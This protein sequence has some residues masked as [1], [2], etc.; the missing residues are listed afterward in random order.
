MT[1]RSAGRGAEVRSAIAVAFGAGS[2]GAAVGLLAASGSLLARAAG[3]PPAAHLAGAIVAVLGLGLGRCALRHAG[4][5]V[6]HDAALRTLARSRV[7]LYEGLSARTP[8]GLHGRPYGR[9][10]GLLA[11][12]A[13][14]VVGRE[15]HGL[16]PMAAAGAAGS[17]AVVVEWSLLPPAGMALLGALMLGGVGAPWAAHRAAVRARRRSA[18]AR[19]E[20][21][22]LAVE[23]LR[24]LPDLLACDAA[25]RRLHGLRRID[26]VVT[27]AEGRSAWSAGLAAGVTTLATGAA[28]F[29]ALLL[30]VAAVREGRLD[31]AGLAV[32][33]LI[34]LAAVEAV[35]V[36]SA[37]IGHHLRSRR[38]AALIRAVLDAPGSV[39][40]PAE[41]LPLPL[42]RHGGYGLCVRALRA[43]GTGDAGAPVSGLDLELPPGRRVALT[44]HGGAGRSALVAVL[45]RLCDYEGSVTLNGVE[46]RDL[47]GTDVRRIVGLC[48]RDAH[49]FTATVAENIRVARPGA[50]DAEVAHAVERAGLGPWA[51][52]LPD[53]LATPL[54]EP[55]SLAEPTSFA[56]PTSQ[57]G[58]GVPVPDGERLRIAV[59]RALLA[60]FPVLIVDEPELADEP[61]H[62][63]LADVF[64]ASA[65]RTVLLMMRRRPTPGADAVLCGMDEVIA[66]DDQPSR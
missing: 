57:G 66:L 25:P 34:P 12:A 21:S 54:G 53:G 59:A 28:L 46:L 50:T 49:V 26:A 18:A 3:R 27:R 48:A 45:L 1:I 33:V 5:L 62:A 58:R 47:C 15:R 9:L 39:T 35:T 56:E 14:G 11:R 36:L 2:L 43:G 7:R 55:T 64:A 44:G 37:A 13:D 61:G 41:P 17:A 31:R 20:L 29:C 38:E 60:D 32:A 42:P 8:S 23:T 40:E 65:G 51:A 30:G 52:A 16:M 4:R 22:R 24:G 10:L 6:S 63:V 19:T